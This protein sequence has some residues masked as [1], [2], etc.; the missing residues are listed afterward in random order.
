MAGTSLSRLA[1]AAL[2]GVIC[3]LSAWAVG[4]VLA[5]AFSCAPPVAW[6]PGW[7]WPCLG[8]GRQVRELVRAGWGTALPAML[9]CAAFLALTLAPRR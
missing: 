8:T 3:G 7:A 5:D 1:A 2:A 4:L 9:G 6:W